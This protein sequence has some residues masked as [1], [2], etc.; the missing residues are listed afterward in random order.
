VYSSLVQTIHLSV[1][2]SRDPNVPFA[3]EPMKRILK[4]FLQPRDI[5]VIF[6]NTEYA[7]IFSLGT[8]KIIPLLDSMIFT[9][10]ME[11]TPTFWE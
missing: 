4:D 11:S 9:P 7:L 5:N 3:L 2:V 8:F 6:F 1:A 10:S